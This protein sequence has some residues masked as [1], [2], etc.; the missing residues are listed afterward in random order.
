MDK[1]LKMS[2]HFVGNVSINADGQICDDKYFRGS[3]DIAEDYYE[4]ICHAI[5]SHDELVENMQHYKQEAEQWE[6]RATSEASRVQDLQAEVERLRQALIDAATSLETIHVRS[7]GEDSF[8]DSKQE[9]RS[10]AGSRAK[11]ARVAL[12]EQ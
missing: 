8:L 7:Y 6:A 10:Y 11:I 4:P 2:S 1:Y 9:M 5:N 3:T 12:S